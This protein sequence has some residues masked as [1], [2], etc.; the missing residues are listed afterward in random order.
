M[1][2]SEK[3]SKIF[4]IVMYSLF[5][6]CILGLIAFIYMQSGKVNDCAKR[7]GYAVDTSQGWVCAKLEK[8]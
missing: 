7:G 8:V 6:L 1:M 4:A 5:A 3:F 2:N